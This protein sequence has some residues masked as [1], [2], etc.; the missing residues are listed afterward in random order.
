MLFMLGWR[1]AADFGKA[2]S[3]SSILAS[4]D[5][6]GLSHRAVEKI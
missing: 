2:A 3:A 5:R 6:L 4:T 1:N